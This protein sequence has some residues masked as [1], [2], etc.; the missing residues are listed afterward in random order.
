M[1]K[2][3][4]IDDDIQICKLLAG[5]L[6][7]NGFATDVAYSAAAGIKKFREQN[8]FNI[9]I[10]DFKLGDKNGCDVLQEIKSINEQ[11]HFII[12]TGY[13]DTK[14]AV[15][16]IKN[17]ALDYITKPLIPDEII[18]VLNQP[19]THAYSNGT[20]EKKEANA[21]TAAAPPPEEIFKGNS[22]LALELKRQIELIAPTNY[23]VILYG[24]SGTGK[25]VM[26][27]NIHALSKRKDAPFVALDCGTLSKELAASELFGHIKGSFTGA[28]TDKVGHFE[29]AN[30]GTIFLDEI[31]NLSYDVQASLLRVIQ[32]RK[33]KRIGDTKE[34]SVDVRILVA[35]NEN[36]KDAYQR[37]TFREDL[38]HRF[39]E[40][41]LDI[42]P[43]RKRQ[44]DLMHFAR[45]FL[46]HAN[47]E[48]GKNIK[49]FDDE[50][51]Q[52]FMQ[53][54]WPGNLREMKNV[55]RRMAL[56]CDGDILTG[57]MMPAEITAHMPGIQ[58]LVQG[59]GI[60]NAKMINIEELSDRSLEENFE[61]KSTAAR[62]E[63]NIIKSILQRVNNNKAKAARL[64]KIDRKTLYNKL[65]EFGI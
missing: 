4:I 16:A 20:R 18:A 32:E 35:S 14:I 30:G 15:Q 5:F 3:L 63:Y 8:D 21:G 51:V 34:I 44:D 25:E 53:Y 64:L 58:H 48:L 60:A 41:T 47:A 46:A 7:K 45:F 9:V 12:I 31:G 61:L 28:V 10:C 43:L 11:V 33:F 52:I 50:L 23:S 40:F 38:Y 55:I 49:G 56:L 62:I 2:I 42:P 1:K 29:M 24:E 17:G 37:G 65:K 19:N 26:A 59:A 39:N 22:P 6:E 13:S 36:L 57:S 27:R 54:N